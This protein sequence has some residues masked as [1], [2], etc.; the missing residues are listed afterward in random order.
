MSTSEFDLISVIKQSRSEDDANPEVIFAN[1]TK[2]S[3]KFRVPD[4]CE[5]TMES[6]FRPY[7]VS[8][9]TRANS[10]D[11]IRKARLVAVVR[12]TCKAVATLFMAFA[13]IAGIDGY[14]QVQFE[15][16]QTI[17]K[18]LLRLLEGCEKSDELRNYKLW[19]L[20]DVLG[21]D[22]Q[23]WE[24][25]GSAVRSRLPGAT[26]MERDRRIRQE[27]REIAI[28]NEAVRK[29]EEVRAEREEEAERQATGYW[30]LGGGYWHHGSL[31]TFY[32]CL[33]AI[34]P[35]PGAPPSS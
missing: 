23:R 12:P 30:D 25:E 20:S 33:L 6:V 29:E 24:R 32:L 8:S 35:S 13:N 26:K 15:I 9:F 11:T 4:C 22:L 16:R 31:I 19:E 3:R 27:G 18:C 5:N 2:F 7:Y 14:K 28:E 10:V 1:N 34:P 21:L 17:R